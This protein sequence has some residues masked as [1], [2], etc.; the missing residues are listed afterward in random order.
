MNASTLCVVLHYGSAADT[1]NCVRTLVDID[2]LDVLVA[3]NDPRQDL[4]APVEFLEKVE[5]FRTGRSTGFAQANN[6]AV[7]H[8]RTR[9]QDAVLLLNNDTLLTE[10]S[11]TEL[12]A[13]LHG[14]DVGAVGPCM[15]TTADPADIWACGGVISRSRVVIV[16]RQPPPDGLPCD[17]DYIPGAAILCRLE[18]WDLSGGLPEKYFLGYEEAEFALRVRDLGYRIMVAPR[19]IVLHNVGMSS[20]QRQPMYVYNSV[21]GRIR[22][23]QYL[24]GRVLG[25]L[26]A[27]GNALFDVRSTRLGLRLWLRAVTDEMRGSAFDREALQAVARRFP[28]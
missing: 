17:V 21:R 7:R 19:A 1:W 26:L 6:M 8:G 16:G 25:S 27:A 18:A 28:G 11:L 20:Q 4:K 2:N 13:V 12:L 9:H 3:D 24:W 10:G 14:S 15:P 22:F 23:G 5:I